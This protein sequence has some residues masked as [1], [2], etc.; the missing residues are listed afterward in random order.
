[1]ERVSAVKCVCNAFRILLTHPVLLCI[2]WEREKDTWVVC[3]YVYCM[4]ILWLCMLDQE[5]WCSLACGCC[6]IRP[7]PYSLMSS[8]VFWE[9][10]FPVNIDSR[11]QR[12]K[13]EGKPSETCPYLATTCIWEPPAEL[14]WLR[15]GF[16]PQYPAMVKGNWTQHYILTNM[17]V[18]IM[19]L[20]L[21]IN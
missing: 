20:C 14:G 9:L 19:V 16:S 2:L 6:C 17:S 8:Q 15:H 3:S 21:Y 1:M 12:V 7:L 13:D 18:K 10:Q 5:M 4:W 11:K